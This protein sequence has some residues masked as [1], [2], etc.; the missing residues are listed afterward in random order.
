MPVLVKS[1][2]VLPTRTDYVDNQQQ[3][4]LTQ[5]TLTVGAG[6]NGGFSLYEDAGEGLGY[7]SGQ[8]TSTPITWSDST[9]T[10]T[11]GAT[12]GTYP[13]A[14]TSRAYTLRLTN[15]TAPTA[16]SVDGT[17]VPETAWSYNTNK[18]TVTV[19]TASLSVSGAH[20]VTLSGNGTGNPQAGEALSASGTCLTARASTDGQPV[21]LAACDHS[22]GQQFTPP[23]SGSVRVQGKCLDV[24]GGATANGT[25][26]QVYTCNSTGAQTWRLRADG[27]LVNPASGRCLDS[28]AATL[29]IYD[30][31]TATGQV[32]RF[33]P[34]PVSG[35]GGLCVD[36]ADA[37]PSSGTAVQLYGCNSSDAQRWS[38]P[39][40]GTV[41]TFGKCLDVAH[42]AAANST[43][44][45]L[46]DCN[47]TGSQ[48]WVTQA[49][50][51]LLNPQSGRCLDDPQGAGTAGDLL[52]IHDCNGSAAQLFRLGS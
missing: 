52:Q 41:R 18:R 23:A 31:S 10:L 24:A 48:T 4:A 35:P 27:R 50:G 28:G 11:V 44:V 47:G 30:C 12:T 7:R 17:Q 13:G 20:T 14:A 45:Q 39:G 8:S 40:D 19:T 34:G 21:E 3:R 38:A 6:A 22:A 16:V 42:G 49:N 32:W 36:V 25:A 1:G 46:W 43:P 29:R 33:P 5:L 37:D 15:S 26:V 9:R 51:S 2:G